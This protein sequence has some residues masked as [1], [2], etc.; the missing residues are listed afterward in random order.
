M[1]DN[2]DNSQVNHGGSI[3]NIINR[4]LPWVCVAFLIAIMCVYAATR[5][6]DI[7]EQA[8]QTAWLA[9]TD[10]LLLRDYTDK[11]R[12]ELAAHGIKPPDYPPELSKPH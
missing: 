6:A 4:P 3:L 8:K 11:L 1:D 7:A 5:A 9:Q 2:I 12:I 10:A